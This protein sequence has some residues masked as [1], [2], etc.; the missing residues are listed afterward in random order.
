MGRDEVASLLQARG[1]DLAALYARADE[2]RRICCG[3]GVPVRAIIE[4]SNMC[5]NDCLY[6]GLRA[7]NAVP[8]R[9]RMSPEEILQAVARVAAAGVAGTVVLQAGETPGYRDEEITALLRQI[10]G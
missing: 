2:A 8:R 6:C 9:Y 7:S 3:D 5:A 1:P 4:F 10:R